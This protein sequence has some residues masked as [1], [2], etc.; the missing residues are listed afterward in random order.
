MKRIL[1]NLTRS[2]TFKI[3]SLENKGENGERGREKEIN[4]MAYF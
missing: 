2:K 4:L 3:L 1:S